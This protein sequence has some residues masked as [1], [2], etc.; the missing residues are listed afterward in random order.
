[1]KVFGKQS[2]NVT[3]EGRLCLVRRK[4]RR[5]PFDIC[6]GSL[7]SGL[8]LIKQ[9]LADDLRR[10]LKLLLVLDLDHTVV[11]ASVDPRWLFLALNYELI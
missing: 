3:T 11:H 4:F 7:S 10:N 9:K 1:M 5:T 8:A 2:L 6:S